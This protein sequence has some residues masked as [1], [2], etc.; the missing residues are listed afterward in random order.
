MPDE[1]PRLFLS[2]GVHDASEIAERLHRDLTTRGYEVWQDVK[3]L[4][5]YVAALLREGRQQAR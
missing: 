2:Y 3:R 1:P 4:R 5:Q